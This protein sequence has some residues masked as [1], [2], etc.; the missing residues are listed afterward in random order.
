MLIRNSVNNNQTDG[1]N[2]HAAI[3]NQI[4]NSIE[5]MKLVNIPDTGLLND[6]LDTIKEEKNFSE[7]W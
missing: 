2:I 1:S 6:L 4:N 7:N 5:I 3:Q